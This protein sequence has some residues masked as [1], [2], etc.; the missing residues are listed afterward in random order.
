MRH[1]LLLLLLLPAL[2]SGATSERG[3]QIQYA[4]GQN[5]VPVYEGWTRNPD[6]SA[7][8]TF[9]YMN[10]NYEEQLDIPVGADNRFEP[11]EADR[12]QPTHFHVRRQMFVFEVVV[13]RDW[14]SKELVWS[15]TA[16]GRTDKAYATLKPDYELS[17]VVVRENRLQDMGQGGGE[18]NT[19]PTI[20]LDGAVRRSTGVSTP[21]SLAVSV[22]DDGFPTPRPSR[23]PS[24]APPRVPKPNPVTQAVVKPNP[25]VGLT[26]TWVHYRGPGTVSFNPASPSIRDG[27]AT[28]TAAFSQPGTYVL[29]AYADDSVLTASTDVTV[30]VRP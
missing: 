29:R 11:G 15:L 8:M 7:T 27:K 10:R 9:G 12:G 20:R 25:E 21:V 3:S 13:P 22:A 19:R 18:P 2:A 26:V 16:H 17:D 28:T 24:G 30:D 6:G 5:V 14:G 23:R 4:I 1:L